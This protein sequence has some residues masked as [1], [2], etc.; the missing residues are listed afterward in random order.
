MSNQQDIPSKYFQTEAQGCLMTLV[1]GAV[2]FSVPV[3]CLVASLL[4]ADFQQ[5]NWEHVVLRWAACRE[6]G[7]HHIGQRPL[8]MLTEASATVS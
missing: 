8:R 5:L 2:C 1:F 7:A 6:V 4:Q 3:F